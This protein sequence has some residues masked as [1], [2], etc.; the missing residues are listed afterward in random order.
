MRGT[1]A[2]LVLVQRVMQGLGVM[3]GG[4]PQMVLLPLLLL[5][6][7]V[8]QA[9]SLAVDHQPHQVQFLGPLATRASARAARP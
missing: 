8:Q 9:V 6:V 4:L 7:L 3:Q 2:A 1:P 5:L